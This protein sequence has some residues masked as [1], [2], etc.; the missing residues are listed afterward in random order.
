MVVCF[1]FCYISIFC[2]QTGVF[3]KKNSFFNVTSYTPSS[4]G[5]VTVMKSDSILTH[6][7]L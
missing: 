4:H 3:Y 6:I 5:C 1:Y 2:I 7:A